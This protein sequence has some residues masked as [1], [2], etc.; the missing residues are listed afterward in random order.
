ME[1]DLAGAEEWGRRW[2]ARTGSMTVEEITLLTRAVGD[3]ALRPDAL[4]L[5]DDWEVA[6]GAR[7]HDLAFYRVLLGDNEGAIRVLSRGTP[8]GGED[9]LRRAPVRPPRESACSN[10]AL[11]VGR[12]RVA[13]RPAAGLRMTHD[14]AVAVPLQDGGAP[15]HM[16]EPLLPVVG[17]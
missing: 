9:P 14:P 4:G 10:R 13:A 7:W 2:A 8:G 17:P 6:P 12:I 1:G 5:L 11:P 16:I 15:A 3:E